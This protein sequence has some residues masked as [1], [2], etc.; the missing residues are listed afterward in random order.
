M[1]N[2]RL[3]EELGIEMGHKL[4]VDNNHVNCPIKKDGGF[5]CPK[6]AYSISTSDIQVF[7]NTTTWWYCE[8]PDI[9]DFNKLQE[10]EMT[11][12]LKTEYRKQNYFL[13]KDDDFVYLSRNGKHC[14]VFS[15][16]K[17]SIAVKEKYV[18]SMCK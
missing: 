2:H 13:S 15:S 3:L 4:I 17:I 11:A 1:T 12:L 9:Q 18:E 8:H 10:N 14:K 6:C 16:Y 5:P 7:L